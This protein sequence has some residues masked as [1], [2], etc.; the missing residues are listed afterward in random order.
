MGL[1]YEQ[2]AE[3]YR[4][5]RAAKVPT[6]GVRAIDPERLSAFV[7]W[8]RA[9]PGRT[10]SVRRTGS[11]GRRPLPEL[12]DVMARLRMQR[13]LG[14]M[15]EHEPVMAAFVV[16]AAFGVSQRI[17]GERLRERAPAHVVVDKPRRPGEKEQI[18]FNQSLIPSLIE[19]GQLWLWQRWA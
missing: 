7:S 13:L 2:V 6:D 12:P 19:Q 11:E 16:G 14:E 17:T 5:I 4:A 3:L 15:E 10:P 8:G 1:T 18:R 9:T